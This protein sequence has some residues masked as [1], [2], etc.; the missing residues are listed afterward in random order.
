MA[1]G[2]AGLEPG[3]I[4][5]EERVHLDTVRP[6]MRQPHPEVLRTV[7]RAEEGIGDIH[8]LAIASDVHHV[9]LHAGTDAAGQPRLFEV[10]YIPLLDLVAAEATDVQEAV[11]R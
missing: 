9:R 1:S 6:D 8:P 10:A 2:W 3:Q 11:I 4:D 5:L 7:Q